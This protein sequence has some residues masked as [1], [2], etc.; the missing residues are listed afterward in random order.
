MPNEGIKCDA[1]IGVSPSYKTI[2][3][4]QS[5]DVAREVYSENCSLEL[6]MK[7]GSVSLIGPVVM[8]GENG[9]KEMLRPGV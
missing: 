8:T 1:V 4:A 2:D 6:H 5:I 9:E 7:D 3:I